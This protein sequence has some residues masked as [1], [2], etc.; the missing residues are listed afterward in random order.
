MVTEKL[1]SGKR[2]LEALRSVSFHVHTA[3]WAN[4]TEEGKWFLYLAS[5][6]VD[7]QGPAAA[8][9]TV[10]RVIRQM[11]DL[12]IDPFE[13]RVV[14]PNDPMAEAVR[15]VIRPKVVAGPFATPNPKPHPG[16]TSFGFGG[17]LSA[18]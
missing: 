13:V 8:Y 18:G 4:P 1:D 2:L 5:P 11:P 6:V 16:M 10:Y 15:E 14:G 7:E 9:R 3:F 17:G 12:W